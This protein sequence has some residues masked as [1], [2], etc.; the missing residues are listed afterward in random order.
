MPMVE[1]AIDGDR[2]GW[3]SG[4]CAVQKEVDGMQMAFD[5]FIVRADLTIEV[6]QDL[7]EAIH[8]DRGVGALFIGRSG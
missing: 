4:S 1:R 6:L 7:E 5:A 3:S 2:S 8:C